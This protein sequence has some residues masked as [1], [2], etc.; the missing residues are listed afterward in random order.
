M[1]KTGESY[2]TARAKVV[3]RSATE[4]KTDSVAAARAASASPAPKVDYARLA[5]MA[6]ATIKAKTGCAWDR[7]V[8]ALDHYG[9]DKMSHGEIA[10]LVSTKYQIDGWW[11]QCVTVGYERIR[12]LRARG[13]R[14]DGRWEASKSKTYAV[15]VAE[16]FD[17]WNT[18][19]LRAKWLPEKITVS[20]ATPHKSM[21]F[22]MPD[23]T[24]VE[25]YFQAKGEKSIVGVQHTRL[26]SK[27]DAD[28]RKKF[29][30]ERLAA[31]NELLA[32]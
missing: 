19:K 30:S 6:D 18:A 32:E 16:L 7:W 25:L 23:G 29:W 13:Q 2:T 22:K 28:Q 27:A 24:S 5:G 4:R 12:G 31:L 11:A 20:R 9:A 17:A 14:R 3:A 8:F 10:A 21:R 26:P 15:P 1:S